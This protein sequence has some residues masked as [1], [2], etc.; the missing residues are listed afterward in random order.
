RTLSAGG[1]L[2]VELEQRAW[3]QR[4][5]FRDAGGALVLQSRRRAERRREL[6]GKLDAGVRLTGW[7][8]V[9]ADL[10]AAALPDAAPLLERLAPLATPQALLERALRRKLPPALAQLAPL[11]TGEAQGAEATRA[12][13][14]MV[15]DALLSR[16]DLWRAVAS[17]DVAALAGQLVEALGAADAGAAVAAELR[18][19]LER[20]LDSLST[21]ARRALEALADRVA[22]QR[23]AQ[24]L[25][26]ELQ[27]VGMQVGRSARGAA[28]LLQ[29]LLDFLQ[30]YGDLRA[31]LVAAAKDSL[32]FRLQL[33]LEWEQARAGEDAFDQDLRIPAEA[34]DTAAAA[35]DFQRWLLGRRLA[36][37][38][39]PFGSPA[40]R[41]QGGWTA[42]AHRLRAFASTL[43]LDLGFSSLKAR[44]LLKADTR[45]ETGPGGVL[46]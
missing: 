6:S 11:L 16:F 35:G 14:D 24:A 15:A 45:V 3:R 10:V 2:S 42:S 27:A 12:L 33:A 31:R 37:P 29:P 4:R 19:W 41:L 5:V 32:D 13:R 18:A 38:E 21:A 17:G 7:G 26:R 30:A 39:R 25:L 28:G 34:L 8:S 22:A 46:L 20:L 23:Q 1:A 44:T 36:D 40:A 9:A 43:S